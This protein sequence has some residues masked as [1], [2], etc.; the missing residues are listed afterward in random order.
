MLKD[1]T[2]AKGYKDLIQVIE[3]LDWKIT[4]KVYS[5][6]ENPMQ[7]TNVDYNEEIETIILANKVDESSSEWLSLSDLQKEE[8]TEFH[9][10]GWTNFLRVWRRHQPRFVLFNDDDNLLPNE[11]DLQS[12]TDVKQKADGKQAV[13]NLLTIAG[14]EI[15]K[16]ESGNPRAI[17]QY[18]AA[19]NKNVTVK[20][21][22]FWTQRIGKAN[23]ISVEI[24]LKNRDTSDKESAGKPYLQFWVKDEEHALHPKQRS[25][26]VRWF[27]SFYLSL[28]ADSLRKVS[29][30]S[31][32]L[33]DEPGANLHARAQEDV[34]RVL[35]DIRKSNQIIY[36]THSQ[37]LIEFNNLYR[38]LAVQRKDENNEESDTII[39]PAYHLGNASTNTLSPILESMGID[40]SSQTVI[41]K[42]N[43]I[44]L[45]EISAFYYFNSFAIL[46]DRGKY[47][48]LPATG[49]SNIEQLALLFLGWGLKFGIIMDDDSAGRKAYQSIVKNI[50]LGNEEQARNNMSRIKKCDGIEDLFSEKYFLKYV[51]KQDKPH[52]ITAKNNS[53]LA[54][55][56]KISKPMS[57][58]GFYLDVR[59]N[60][61][62]INLL[63]E[64]TQNS[65]NNVMDEIERLILNQA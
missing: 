62:N 47:N 25:K 14:I 58:L 56:L 60:G 57:A 27:L 63:D 33:I 24:E 13:L 16:L 30:K 49:V 44:L 39:L 42:Q 17:K 11:I 2:G 8:Y 41:S 50:Y 37:H 28:K 46:I 53:D 19:A 54:K 45:E 6:V 29:S 51:I 65:I 7:F 18:M 34:L 52:G 32:F 3:K 48:Y 20:L 31:L 38:L 64:E 5:H 1:Y 36:T 35:D 4:R 12:L 22:E 26:G 40:L 23:K 43:N 9:A 21:H 10:L 59:D 15:S 55:I 61:L